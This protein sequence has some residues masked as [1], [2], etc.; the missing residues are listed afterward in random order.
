MSLLSGDPVPGARE[1]YYSLTR[2]ISPGGV[3]LITDAPIP[4]DSNVRLEIALSRV[5]K[6]VR[7]T[8][9]VRWVELLYG[10]GVYEMG[11]EFTDIGP[12]GIGAI[13]EYVYK[14]NIV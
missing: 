7:A 2:D 11:I 6:V 12:E 14:R 3:R 10:D 5:R 8:G 9:K 1:A 4:I 13:L